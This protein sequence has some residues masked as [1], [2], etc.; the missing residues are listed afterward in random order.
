[1]C[2]CWVEKIFFFLFSFLTLYCVWQM[3][4]PCICYG[5]EATNVN[6]FERIVVI[7]TVFALE[8]GKNPSK[9][10][11]F[12]FHFNGTLNVGFSILEKCFRYSSRVHI[13]KLSKE[14]FLEQS[15]CFFM[16][17][18]DSSY[19]IEIIITGI[20]IWIET[21][22]FTG[23]HSQNARSDRRGH[24]PM[25]TIT[26]KLIHQMFELSKNRWNVSFYQK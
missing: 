10:I 23:K 25:N 5:G 26:S 8:S 22:P 14:F 17:F 13:W 12:R 7:I 21:I 19:E 2:F 20:S 16:C 18:A 1:M 11:E 15:F 6:A 24:K 9:S 3:L 4:C